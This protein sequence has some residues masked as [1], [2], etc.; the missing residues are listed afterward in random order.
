MATTTTTNAA[1][2]LV[3]EL[4]AKR[5]RLEQ[6]ATELVAIKLLLE[7][8]KGMKAEAIEL[9]REI[10]VTAMNV[11]SGAITVTKGYS[12]QRTDLKAAE[13]ALEAAGI[14]V[15]KATTVVNEGVKITPR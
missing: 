14:P 15:P 4:A 11:E 3:D 8:E 12:F 1:R 10:G 5:A 2:P 9:M 13:A 6:L 7:E